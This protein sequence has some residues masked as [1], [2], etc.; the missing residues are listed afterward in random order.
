MEYQLADLYEGVVERVP[1]REALVVDGQGRWTYA[2]LDARGNRLAHHLLEA[3]LEPGEHVGFYLPNHVEYVDGL[4][5][6]AKTSTV[7][8]NVNY[9]YVADELAYLFDD[10][11]LAGLVLHADFLDRYR[12]VADRIDTLR[13]VLVVGAG[14]DTD[15]P[16]GVVRYEEAVA[17][18]PDTRPRTGE[19][20]PDDHFIIYTGGTT[21]MP[22]GVVWTHESLFF[23][24]MGGGS[25]VEEPVSTPEE[26]PERIDLD[27]DPM[28]M[29]SA[30]PLMH[31][32]CI[33]G[34]FIGFWGGNRVVLTPEYSGHGALRLIED[35]Q[36]NTLSI[37]GDAMALPL[38]E[39]MD[40][41]VADGDPYDT[42]SL[43]A[44][45][46]AGAIMSTAVKDKLQDRLGE[47]MIIDSFG[48]S[49][50]GY[51]GAATADSSPDSGLKFD[52]TDDT[53]IVS[54]DLR[55]LEPGSEEVGFVA[56]TGHIP[57]G[58]YGDPEK[59][60]ETFPEIEGRRWV[61]MG[62]RARIDE[63]GVI[64]VLGRGS[65]CINTG[66]EKV[67]PEEVEAALKSHEDIV[68]AVVAGIPDERW[69]ER[70][71]AVLQIRDGA[72]APSQEEV[73]EHLADRV[74]RYKVPRLTAVVEE[75]ERSP[76]G[77]PSYKWARQVLAEQA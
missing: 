30:P 1:D 16:D 21:G 77:K 62:D 71:A 23:A 49:E 64:H 19:R 44:V 45:S 29:F 7:P 67:F 38:I 59:T 69:G 48:S 73:E 14:A 51:N 39:A 27:G 2:E 9:R 15:L 26:L 60:A 10:A 22:K 68:D 34:T 54:E 35:E 66:G 17:D 32:A 20:S 55:I 63:D 8:I 18:R 56:Q 65:V 46:T 40:E 3:G 37:V 12:K 11:D 57:E 5:A 72:D 6:T 58:Y 4:L 52:M 61:L 13:H 74:A 47:V 41:A 28:T 50:T 25:P 53:A 36:V 43:L 33:L 42:S 24:G 70:V 31:G 75:V 76:A